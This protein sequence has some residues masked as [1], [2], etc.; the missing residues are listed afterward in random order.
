MSP[1]PPIPKQDS[2][3][4]WANTGAAVFGA[5][6]VPQNKG[7]DEAS[8]DEDATSNVEI[9]FEPVVSLPEVWIIAV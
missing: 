2:N 5:A 3:F 9:D 8:G 7:E 6:T 4:T 1:V